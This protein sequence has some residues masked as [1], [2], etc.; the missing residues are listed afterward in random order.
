MPVHDTDLPDPRFLL[1]K[2][3][4]K[5]RRSMGQHFLVNLEAA[6]SIARIAADRPGVD[7]I[8]IGPGL[9]TLTAALL[10]EGARVTAVERDRA[11][12]DILA[13][14]LGKS[15]LFRIV[16]ADA[17]S[18]DFSSIGGEAVAVGNLP[19]NV[20]T[21][22]VLRAIG[23]RRSLRRMVFMLQAEVADR[24]AAGP[25]SRTCGALSLLVQ[26]VCDV[27]KLLHLKPGS[28]FPKPKVESSVIE[29][30]P[31]KTPRIGDLDYERFRRVVNA[32][33]SKR[34][35]TLKNALSGAGVW[36]E[37]DVALA[38]RFCGIDP[39]RR[40]E[41]LSVEEF[42]GLARRLPG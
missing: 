40:A 29:L 9:G 28:F 5:P 31:Q 22:I 2:Y 20:G 19:Y 21:L 24:I 13:A 1:R 3:G 7:V 17:M 39:T 36:T 25:G 10:R 16:E 26:G 37:D 42:A 38:L 35:K 32:G 23:F 8:E 18:F 11:M 33:F 6:R 41:T 30:T 15:P 12:I 14:E 27:R 34:R 4:L